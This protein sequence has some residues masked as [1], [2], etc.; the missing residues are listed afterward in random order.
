MLGRPGALQAA[1]V[2]PSA[3]RNASGWNAS[4]AG[5]RPPHRCARLDTADTENSTGTSPSPP[6]PTASPAWLP[7]PPD[8][9]PTLHPPHPA[10]PIHPA[11]PTIPQKTRPASPASAPPLGENTPS[12]APSSAPAYLKNNGKCKCN[13]KARACWKRVCIPT[14][15][16][17]RLRQGW[18]TRLFLAGRGRTDNCDGKNKQRQKQMWGFFASLSDCLGCQGEWLWKRRK[19]VERVF[20]FPTAP[21]TTAGEV[22]GRLRGARVLREPWR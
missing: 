20:R 2:H 5:S 9:T 14:L 4:S 18:R 16:A 21:T 22:D 7:S 1:R 10:T 6:Q 11:I 8:P 3:R 19:M 12:S 17:M 13:S 15:V